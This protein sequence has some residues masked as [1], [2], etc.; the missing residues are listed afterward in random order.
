[1]HGVLP[2]RVSPPF[3]TTASTFASELV[4]RGAGRREQEAIAKAVYTINDRDFDIALQSIV[5]QAVI[6]QH[7]IALWISLHSRMCRSG[8]VFADPYRHVSRRA[9][10]NVHRLLAELCCLHRH[11]AA[12]VLYLHSRD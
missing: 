12:V 11:V 1:M 10:S 6:A 4:V 2:G 7:N 5:L 9:I 3:T 8:P